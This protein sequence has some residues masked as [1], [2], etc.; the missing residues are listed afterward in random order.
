[1][2]RKGGQA[3]IDFFSDLNIKPNVINICVELVFLFSKL[4]FFLLQ[5]FQ[6]LCKLR[7]LFSLKITQK[8]YIIFLKIKTCRNYTK[9]PKISKYGCYFFIIFLDTVLSSLK[10][11]ISRLKNSTIFF[12]YVIGPELK[13]ML[14]KYQ[15]KVLFPSTEV[16][17]N[18]LLASLLHVL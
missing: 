6:K 15:N 12:K 10:N 2:G 3:I 8:C 18:L 1:M 4:Y 9:I 14:V 17:V 13:I 16:F 11:D 7:L 5:V